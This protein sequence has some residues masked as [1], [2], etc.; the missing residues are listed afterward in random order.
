MEMIEKVTGIVREASSLMVHEGFDV[1]QKGGCANIVTS[2]DI[3][4]Q[5][6]LCRKL[7]ALLPGSGFFCEE[8][9]V[10]DLGKEFVWFIDP[11]DGTTNY[12]R[13]IDSCCISVAL[14][15]REEVVLGI[16]YSPARGEMYCAEKGKGATLNGKPIHVSQRSFGDSLFCTAM[17]TYRKEFAPVCND[18]IMETFFQCNDLRRFG[19]CA[20]ELCFM[21]TGV[22]ELYF[23]IRLQPWD[24]AAGS[25]I[26]EEAGGCCCN[27]D[28]K[29]PRM[30]GPDLLAAANSRESLNRLHSIIRRHLDAIPYID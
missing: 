14:R 29:S 24:Y 17:S 4:V 6:F 9:D 12:A 20:M 7:S 11:I 16:V 21:A 18:I 30:D 26:L 23:E 3:A 5:N 1:E 15:H 10:H 2:S 8:K 13:G 25:L 27:L 28:G 19:S 22:A